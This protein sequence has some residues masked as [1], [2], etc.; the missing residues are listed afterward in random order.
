MFQ[1]C[2]VCVDIE[3]HIGDETKLSSTAHIKKSPVRWNLGDCSSVKGSEYHFKALYIQR[4][5][6][7]P[8][9]QLLSCYS[10]PP[11]VGWKGA[12]IT[13]DGHRYCDNFVGYRFLQKLNIIFLR[14]SSLDFSQ[15]KR[16]NY[17]ISRHLFQKKKYLGRS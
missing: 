11:A 9:I 6:L 3:L 5:C 8:G 16:Y 7:Q 15:S 12:Y 1:H 17:E 10:D 13:I 14:N 4:C 2:L